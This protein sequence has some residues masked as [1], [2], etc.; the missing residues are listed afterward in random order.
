MAQ[1]SEQQ[2]LRL[3]M[4]PL[5]AIYAVA[6]AYLAPE[7]LSRRQIIRAIEHGLSCEQALGERIFEL[8][9]MNL[10]EFYAKMPREFPEDFDEA[11]FRELTAVRQILE[12]S[13]L[14]VEMTADF[15]RSLCR[16]ARFVAEGS[17]FPSGI[18]QAAMAAR[19]KRIEA[20]LEGNG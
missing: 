18:S 13:E 6:S 17:I 14:S 7:Q 10:H 20:L 5:Y 12:E 3:A 15:T 9:K 2:V 11:C 1:L 4:S 19:V 8:L 16:L